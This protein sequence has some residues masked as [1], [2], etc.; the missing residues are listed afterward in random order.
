MASS[1]GR[2]VRFPENLVR[3]MGRGASGVRGINLDDGILV[4][5]EVA[6]SDIDVLVVTEK[7]YG[8]RL[9]S[10]NIELQIV[11]VRVLKL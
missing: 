11:V 7:G 8:K 10:V 4:G 3:V 6:N 9:L 5:M 2:L 1:N